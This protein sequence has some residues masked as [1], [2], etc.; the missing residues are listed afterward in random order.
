VQE[1]T[2]NGR[3][4]EQGSVEGASEVDLTAQD[5]SLLLTQMLSGFATARI[6]QAR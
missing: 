2:V 3:R 1:F 5:Q 6:A 4:D